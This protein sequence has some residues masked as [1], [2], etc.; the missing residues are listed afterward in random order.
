MLHRRI[1]SLVLVLFFNH[2]YGMQPYQAQ[3]VHITS[4][5]GVTHF[6]MA[7][8]TFISKDGVRRLKMPPL[9]IT[10][11]L[12]P[13]TR[14][15]PRVCTDQ[16]P[17]FP[18]K[19]ALAWDKPD[20]LIEYYSN[21]RGLHLVSDYQQSIAGSLEQAAKFPAK[22][23]TAIIAFLL[24]KLDPHYIA[25][26]DC[27]LDDATDND[28]RELIRYIATHFAYP[29]TA[30][31]L[32]DSIKSQ[33]IKRLGS[34]LA[35]G[36]SV[37]KGLGAKGLSQTI[38]HDDKEFAVITEHLAH[39]P[40]HLAANLGAAEVVLLLLKYNANAT[41]LD[42]YN[43]PPVKAALYGFKEQESEEV[44]SKRIFLIKELLK[45]MPA[46]KRPLPHEAELLL[47][48]TTV[49]AKVNEV[50][51]SFLPPAP[52]QVKM[53]EDFTP[54]E[55]AHFEKNKKRICAAS[56]LLTALCTGACIVI[57]EKCCKD[58][59]SDEKP[60]QWKVP[61]TATAKGKSNAHKNQRRT[62]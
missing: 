32:Y 51:Q 48:P 22:K 21:W 62:Q 59:N 30:W 43:N 26:V 14:P 52:P 41:R 44:V 42:C 3:V 28:H 39:F 20:G 12:N 27:L 11:E 37:D 2:L 7:T 55:L 13:D 8:S 18:L 6:D 36:V 29:Y 49:R 19:T 10:V 46:D 1:T 60:T 38:I 33:N 4:P 50:F 9:K 31:A 57:Y 54:Q 58:A 25:R 23:V 24:T 47:V 53:I 35:A 17:Q 5:T 45:A 40:L 56:T 15:Y 34:L 16:P 61:P